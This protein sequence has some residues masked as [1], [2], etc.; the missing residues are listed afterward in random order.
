MRF[1][2]YIKAVTFAVFAYPFLLIAE[3]PGTRIIDGTPVSELQYPYVAKLKFNGEILCSGTLVGSRH[4][5]TAG[6]CFFDSRNRRAVGDTDVVVRLGGQEFQSSKVYIHPSYRPRSAACVE[7]ETDAAIVE[8]VST[9][10]GINPVALL[11]SPVP[12]G[13]T[14]VLAGHGTQGEGSNGE[15]GTVPEDGIVNLGST[16][17]EGFGNPP[18]Q[19]SSSTYF[20]WTFDPGESNTASGDSGGPAFLTSG[21][22]IFLAGIT[23]GGDGNAEHGTYS[24]D[25]RVD[26]MA[27]W[28]GSITGATPGNT[29]PGFAG[30][31]A[32]NA[33]QGTLFSYTVPVTGSQ[34][35]TLSVTDLPEGLSFDGATISGTPSQ[36]G[37]FNIQ[38]SASNSAGSAAATLTLI[39]TGFDPSLSIQ[40]ALLQFDFKGSSTD[41]LDLTGRISVGP[42]FSP[43]SKKVTVRIGRFSKQFK[44]GPDGESR[45]SGKSYFDLVGPFKGKFFRKSEVKYFLTL[46]RVPFYDELATLGFPMSDQAVEGQEVPLPVTV[47]IDGIESSATAILRFR[48]RDARWF[49]PK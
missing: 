30:V 40:K 36:R 42:K 45:A 29:A 17:V 15:D 16:V 2:D 37:T 22:Q 31:T 24:L 35:L 43:R 27:A 47:S 23:C 13:A 1:R 9:V 18:E 33:T 20:Y 26:L 39:V 10:G 48:S 12:I 44:L 11:T 41:F 34:P 21:D 5:L 7:G 32:Q 6:H 8:L 19:N 38:L 4:V 3:E 25:T 14:L 49:V 28:I 46:E